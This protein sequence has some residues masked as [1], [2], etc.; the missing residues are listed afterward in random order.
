MN[1]IE[2]LSREISRVQQLKTRY[3]ELRITLGSQVIVEPQIY[4]MNLAIERG[5]AAIGS[6]DVERMMRAVQELKG[7]EE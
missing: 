7:Y 6:G 4:L 1:L 2:G 3:E 5:Q